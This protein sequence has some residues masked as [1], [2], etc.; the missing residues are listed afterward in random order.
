MRLSGQ[1]ADSLLKR[2]L[3]GSTV[4][5]KLRRS[6]FTI[7]TRQK[8]LPEKV[9]IPSEITESALELLAYE[10]ENSNDKYRLIGVGVSG[11]STAESLH[12]EMQLRFEGF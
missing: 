1:V 6:D 8:T 2:D 9:Q 12:D 4:K 5:L 7:L 3:R 10:L 11:F